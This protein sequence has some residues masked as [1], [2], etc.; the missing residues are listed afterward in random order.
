MTITGQSSL[1]KDEIER[2]VR[3]AEANAAEDR[4]RRDEVE[5]RNNGE[6]LLYQTEKV[7]REQGGKLPAEERSTVDARV[8]DLKGALGG[9]DLE[10]IKS[11]TEALMTASQ[12]FTQRLYEAAASESSG[13]APRVGGVR[14]RGRRRR[15]RRRWR[16]AL[17]DP[18]I[19]H[20]GDDGSAGVPF[21]GAAGPDRSSPSYVPPG[22]ITL[23]SSAPL[24]SELG[25][26]VAPALQP[27]RRGFARSPARGARG[28][29]RRRGY[30]RVL[31]R[32]LAR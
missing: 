25:D 26:T 12:Q 8:A 16:R 6:T 31:G 21:G 10:A 7:L 9:S 32:V 20:D 23:L 11:A 27:S 28:V 1:A 17:S 19:R 30:G 5:V 29:R 3:D 4:R 14:R 24:S 15:N 18:S 2:M 22:D 13:G